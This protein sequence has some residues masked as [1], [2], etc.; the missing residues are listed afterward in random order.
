M[1]QQRKQA[2]GSPP[3][4]VFL[5][6]RKILIGSFAIILFVP[7]LLLAY[8]SYQTA[9]EKI[10]DQM[11]MAAEE[12]LNLL[13]AMLDSF[14]EG[15]K[16][17]TDLLSQSLPDLSLVQS[18]NGTNIGSNDQVRNQLVTV[19]ATHDDVEMVFIGTEAGLYMDSAEVTK[20]ATDYDPR[21]RGWYTQA[22][23]N[24]GSAIVTSPYISA[25]TGNLIVTIAK[26][27]PDGQGVV[28]LS[29]QLVKLAEITKNVRIGEEGYV[30]L[31]DSSR[32]YVYH[33]SYEAGEEAEQTA[34][35]DQLY[36]AES[37]YF[38]FNSSNDQSG[39][40][41]IFQ[42]NDMTGWKLAGVM[43]EQEVEG[44]ASTIFQVTLIVLILSI[45]VGALLVIYIVLSVL[46]PLRRMNDGSLRIAEG[47]LSTDIEVKQMNEFGVLS[48][49]FNKMAGSLR[50]LIHQV[51]EN[52]MQLAAASEQLTANSEHIS[53]SSEQISHTIEEVAHGSVQQVERVQD[54]R[55]EMNDM[56]S[57]LS[58][59][60]SR[61]DDVTAAAGSAQVTATDGNEAIQTAV[62]QMNS[63]G[64]KVK[65]LSDDVSG[66][67]QRSAEIVKFAQVITDIASQTN[68][69]ALNASIEA[70]RAGE[71]G[72]GFAVVASEI[73]KLAEQSSNSA[74][75]ISQ[76]IAAI[77]KDTQVTVTSMEL[78]SSEVQSGVSLVDDAGSSFQEIM[79]SIAAVALQIDKVSTA[80]GQ[81]SGNAANVL[82]AIEVVSGISEDAAA[83]IQQVAASTKDQLL[84]MQEVA[85]ASTMLSKMAEELQ[86][87]V[88]KF[89]I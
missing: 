35:T 32:K 6:I 29:V 3:K 80:A 87:T 13:N 88:G 76:L 18:G 72:K 2:D 77:Q 38:S 41:M 28:G 12:N 44:E 67:G 59:I 15:K 42:T 9:K 84:S 11:V 40:R 79:D 19:K 20:I 10:D 24:K 57:Q 71:Q 58:H 30:F 56:A 8:F 74:Q 5:S 7:T 66:L 39:M 53:T 31:S 63:I 1:K 17:S 23:E 33:P 21:K 27:T 65:T 81:M 78:V 86:D 14:V 60:A 62:T 47:D 25:A 49:N 50:T 82:Q 61:A 73:K 43:Y 52:A 46:R 51:N 64:Q 70:A 83:S 69:L 36:A 34:T 75:Q 54:T 4:M 68:L 22:K 37:G 85:S 55:N 48:T 89:K 26:E 45:I 16:Q